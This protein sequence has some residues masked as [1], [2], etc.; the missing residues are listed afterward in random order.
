MKKAVTYCKLFP[1]LIRDF[2][3]RQ[4]ANLDAI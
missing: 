2:S 4:L 3:A 1:S